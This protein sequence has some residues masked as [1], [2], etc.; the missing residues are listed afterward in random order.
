MCFASSHYGLP[1]ISAK[2][3]IRLFAS[4]PH[5]STTSHL[6]THIQVQTTKYYLHKPKPLLC[7]VSYPPVPTTVPNMKAEA[8]RLGTTSNKLFCA[9]AQFKTGKNKRKPIKD[10]IETADDGRI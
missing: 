3:Q 6:T 1:V 10:S 8:P 5:M 7:L 2:Y 4:T 9:L